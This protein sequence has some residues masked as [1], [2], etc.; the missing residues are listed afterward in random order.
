MRIVDD[1]T[2]RTLRSLMVLA[3]SVILGSTVVWFTLAYVQV[4]VSPAAVLA[5]VSGVVVWAA[6]NSSGGSGTP[7]PPAP[8]A[9]PRRLVTWEDAERAVDLHRKGAISKAQ[10]DATLAAVVPPALSDVPPSDG[11]RRGRR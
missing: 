3:M 1:A 4:V 6:V 8:P 2:E 9:R 7:P 5:L 11:G 10:L